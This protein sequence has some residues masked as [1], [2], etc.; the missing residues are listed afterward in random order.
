MCAKAIEPNIGEW[1]ELP[2]PRKLLS[3]FCLLVSREDHPAFHWDGENGNVETL[4]PDGTCNYEMVP[5]PIRDFRAALTDLKENFA[6]YEKREIDFEIPLG[7]SKL[8]ARVRL[9]QRNHF[10]HLYCEI[11]EGGEKDERDYFLKTYIDGSWMSEDEDRVRISVVGRILDHTGQPIEGVRLA[12]R[13]SNW[14]EHMMEEVQPGGLASQVVFSNEQ[15]EFELNV[16]L[17]PGFLD[18]DEVV[19][20]YKAAP[21]SKWLKAKFEPG[22]IEADPNNVVIRVPEPGGLNIEFD[23]STTQ[24]ANREQ[25]QIALYRRHDYFKLIDV[26]AKG[27][28]NLTGLVP[29]E[30]QVGIVDAGNQLICQSVEVVGSQTAELKLEFVEQIQTTLSLTISRGDTS[31]RQID[32]DEKLS[33]YIISSAFESWSRPESWELNLSE[34]EFDSEGNFKHSYKLKP[35]LGGANRIAIYHHRESEA[36]DGWT[37]S[38]YTGRQNEFKIKGNPLSFEPVLLQYKSESGITIDIRLEEDSQPTA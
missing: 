15:G 17:T 22:V 1:N 8:I 37:D 13:K 10:P 36:E 28:L 12:D 21:I 35:L 26:D 38:E 7:T 24:Y 2:Q 29:G 9:E 27:K 14:N 34:I 18:I 33:F 3:M 4:N 5:P 19:I 11:E 31:D 25:L 30:Y 20:V 32:E 23:L 6:L 16:E